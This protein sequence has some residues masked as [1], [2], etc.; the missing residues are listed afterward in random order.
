MRLST[1]L[2]PDLVLKDLDAR[3]ASGVLGRVARHMEERGAVEDAGPVEEALLARE[4]AHSTAL[5][6]GI[7]VPHATIP[8]LGEPVLTLAVAPDA[9]TFGPEGTDPVRLFFVLLSPPGRESEHIK[10]LARIC[11]LVRHEGF[12]DSIQEAADGEEALQIIERIDQQHV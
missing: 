1:Y 8:G 3:D 11:R 12:V 10:I 2:R 5:G 7:A 4:R 9:V 6:Q